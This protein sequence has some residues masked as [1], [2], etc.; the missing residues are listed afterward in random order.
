LE[1]FKNLFSSC[2]FYRSREVPVKS[3]EFVIKCFGG[4][5]YWDWEG[6]LIKE[7]DHSINHQVVDR[8]SQPH[9]MLTREYVQ[10]QWV[11]D[12]VNTRI[13]LPVH[14]Y[15]LTSKLPPHLSPFVD[16]TKEEYVPERQKQI[17]LLKNPSLKSETKVVSDDAPS[18]ATLE[19]METEY[20]DDLQKE[21]EGVSFSQANAEDED[22]EME[23]VEEEGEEIEEEEEE[24]E[25]EKEEGEEIE[26]EEEGEKEK[27]EG[28]EIEEEEEKEE[29][30]PEEGEEEEGE[31]ENEEEGGEGGEEEE[32]EETGMT[33]EE[34]KKLIVPSKKAKKRKRRELALAVPEEKALSEIMI[35]NKNKWLYKHVK[36]RIRVKQEE[37]D[38]LVAKRL[39]AHSQEEKEQ[40]R[41]LKDKTKQRQ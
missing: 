40:K 35:A 32:E 36:R 30:E 29:G 9:M 20:A 6:T 21:L 28:E 27:E 26:G 13:L 14:E 37:M 34:F 38:R 19:E 1:A 33:E 3:L 7:G 41:K 4:K 17:D 12:C 39:W 10:P 18:E 5:V 23:D 25:G 15:G 22:E 8:S 24:G 2:V 31:G 11:Y 16:P